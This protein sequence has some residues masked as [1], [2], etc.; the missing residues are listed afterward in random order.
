MTLRDLGALARAAIRA[1]S[2]DYAPSMGAALAYYALFSLSP[3]LLIALVVAGWLFPAEVEN[4]VIAGQL[5]SLAGPAGAQALQGLLEA[6]REPGRG[7]FA[8]GLGMVLLVIGA[9]TVFG[10]LQSALDRIWRVPAPPGTSNL[11]R[12]VRS[13]LAAFAMIIATGALLLG[14][15]AGGTLLAARGAAS[16][17]P[18]LAL[19][20][21]EIGLG[22]VIATVLFALIYK[23]VP[24]ARIA[25]RDVGTG[26]LVTAALF[27][28]GKFAIA[29]YIGR[30]GVTSAFGAAGSLAAL[31]VWLYYS[32]QIF[33]L[34]AEFTWVYAHRTGSRSALPS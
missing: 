30:T 20:A 24:R 34:G 23:I 6:A 22:M 18:P 26:A 32:A 5:I 19:H 17:V 1:W 31:L 21:V 7:V 11:W 33:L 3:L 27:S 4:G 14:W 2:D 16:G 28:L 9:T 29:W 15:L 12:L 13:R 10:E 25:W 8:A